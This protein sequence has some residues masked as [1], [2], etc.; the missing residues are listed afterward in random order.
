MTKVKKETNLQQPLAIDL[1][2]ATLIGADRFEFS[3]RTYSQGLKTFVDTQTAEK[4]EVL[5]NEA[6]AALFEIEPF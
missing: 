2:L 3:G 5:Q 4:L 6:G 1:M